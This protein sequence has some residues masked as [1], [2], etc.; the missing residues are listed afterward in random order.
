MN[1]TIKFISA[2]ALLVA[3]SGAFASEGDANADNAWINQAVASQNATPVATSSAPAP[4]AAAGSVR[5]SNTQTVT[6]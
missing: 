2:A 4:V 3:A 6:P 1:K 5:T